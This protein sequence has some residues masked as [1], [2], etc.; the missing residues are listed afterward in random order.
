[1]TAITIPDTAVSGKQSYQ[2]V[3]I[4]DSVFAGTKADTGAN[5]TLKSVKL[6]ANLKYI[7]SNAFKYCT[8]LNNVDFSK[9]VK[10]ERIG[11]NAFMIPMQ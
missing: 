9:A 11:S 6:G 1:M 10:L 3:G 2:V 4:G 5:I 8:R 7:S